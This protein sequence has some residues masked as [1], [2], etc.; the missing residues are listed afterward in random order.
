MVKGCWQVNES[1][2]EEEV[3]VLTPW[4]TL[5]SLQALRWCH[6]SSFRNYLRAFLSVLYKYTCILKMIVQQNENCVSIF[7]VTTIV[8]FPNSCPTFF[9]ETNVIHRM[10]GKF[11]LCN[12]LRKVQSSQGCLERRMMFQLQARAMKWEC[13][14][15]NTYSVNVQTTHS[16]NFMLQHAV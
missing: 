8:L 1:W 11:F 10:M 5:T 13:Y 12:T 4:E 14:L 7:A 6:F 15:K 3:R 9:C 16:C 2:R